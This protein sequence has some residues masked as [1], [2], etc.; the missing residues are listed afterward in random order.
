M[1]SRDYYVDNVSGSDNNGGTSEGSAIVSGT[2]GSTNST[3]TVT[4]DGGS[5]L[6]GV[7]VG[8]TI[9][10]AGETLGIRG[11]DI[12]EI[13]A[14]NDGADTVDVTPTPGTASG[15]TWAIGGAWVTIQKA[16]GTVRAVDIDYVWIKGG[17]DYTEI[18]NVNLIMGIYTPATF[19][20]YTTSTGDGGMFT[21]DGGSVRLNGLTDS[22]AGNAYYVFKNMRIKN[23]TGSGATLA[24]DASV[25]KNCEFINNGG[26]GFF[27][28][29]FW[30]FEECEFSDNTSYGGYSD[31][32][33][34]YVGCRSYRN[35]IYGFRLKSGLLLDC[36]AFSNISD[37]LFFFGSAFEF[38]V[39]SSC[40]VDGDSKDTNTG[41]ALA[42]ATHPLGIVINTI[43]YD[44]ITG[45]DVRPGMNELVISRNNLLNANTTDYVGSAATFKGEVTGAPDF[46][47]EATQ[48]YRL[49]SS[50][51]AKA[52]GFDESQLEGASSG[53]D[54]GARQRIEAG[55]VGGIT[56]LV[57]VGG[58]LVG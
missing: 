41:V 5:D 37:A 19:E 22:I 53:K 6:S 47:A 28:D 45:L 55:G 40:T 42:T 4:L 26:S 57:G 29:D 34:G 30:R 11:G 58:G 15:L 44:C 14:V 2:A 24:M 56:K 33:S 20:G 21:I 43:I 16:M 48:D 13:T 9:R 31:S 7:V 17:T 36:V 12:F 10:I 3:A 23:C 50:S 49:N 35:G 32:F 8:D 1:A 25:C 46:V 38:A 39:V 52:A 27:C 54:I 51:P 18:V